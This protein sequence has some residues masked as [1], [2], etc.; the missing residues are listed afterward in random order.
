METHQFTVKH[1][2]HDHGLYEMYMRQIGK[3]YFIFCMGKNGDPLRN[4]KLTVKI[5]HM[6][7]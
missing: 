5:K 4:E 1:H 3:D 2:R 6:D 7:F